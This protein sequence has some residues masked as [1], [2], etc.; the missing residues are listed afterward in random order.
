ML[1]HHAWHGV[2][3]Q[4]ATTAMKDSTEKWHLDI[5]H[6]TALKDGN[7]AGEKGTQTR[8]QQQRR[9]QMAAQTRMVV[10]ATDSSLQRW[11]QI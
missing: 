7:G 3:E 5:S 6:E 1:C 11:P 9:Q 4:I 2:W 10:A 8:L